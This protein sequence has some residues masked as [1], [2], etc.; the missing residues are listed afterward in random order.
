MYTIHCIVYV[1]LYIVQY[2][3]MYTYMYLGIPYIVH[4]R[5]YA[6]ICS[7]IYLIRSFSLRYIFILVYSTRLSMCE[8]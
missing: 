8:C 6:R 5:M 3:A 7:T 1:Q 2:N 4:I